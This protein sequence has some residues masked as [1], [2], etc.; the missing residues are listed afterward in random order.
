MRQIETE[1]K[2]HCRPEEVI[3]AFID[4]N[5]LEGWWSVER[6][7]IEPKIGGVYL[8]AWGITAQGVKY[9]NSGMIEAYHPSSHLHITNWMYVNPERQILGPQYLKID[10]GINS[11][12]SVLTL[13][14][15]PYPENAGADWDWYY[16]VV[17]DAW[18]F[19]LKE[20]KTY[21]ERKF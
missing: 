2:I 5:H 4:P 10:A 12:G 13:S 9:I 3:S 21:L 1:M 6:S 17:K 18:P 8:L 16:E 20:L 7:F 19:V 11:E 15:G 14:Q